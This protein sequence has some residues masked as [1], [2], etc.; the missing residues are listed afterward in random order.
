MCDLSEEVFEFVDFENPLPFNHALLPRV[1]HRREF[2][3]AEL[4]VNLS[5]RKGTLR[6]SLPGWKDVP[7]KLLIIIFF[8]ALIN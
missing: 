2:F 5:Q 7:Y 8:H 4:H 6:I 1:K 3:G